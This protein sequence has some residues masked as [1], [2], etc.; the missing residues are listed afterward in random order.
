[1]IFWELYLPEAKKDQRNLVSEL[2]QTL[3][4]CNKMFHAL[5]THELAAAAFR[6]CPFGVGAQGSFVIKHISSSNGVC[7]STI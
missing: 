3:G 7:L 6:S 1:M 2:M 5:S 4:P